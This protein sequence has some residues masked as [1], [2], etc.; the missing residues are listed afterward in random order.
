MVVWSAYSSSSFQTKLSGPSAI[1]SP[2]KYYIFRNSESR[3][4]SCRRFSC[5]AERSPNSVT[6]IY[7]VTCLNS[8]AELAAFRIRRLSY[9]PL[10]SDTVQLFYASDFAVAIYPPDSTGNSWQSPGI[11]AESQQFS[12]PYQ[13]SGQ[14]G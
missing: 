1:R 10:K 9:R 3:Q 2:N 11:S 5:H 13:I 14:L 6:S 7:F 4:P 12:A 8:S